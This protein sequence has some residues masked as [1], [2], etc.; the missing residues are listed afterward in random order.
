MELL[1]KILI[2]IHALTGGIGLISGIASIFVKKGSRLHTR[3]GKIFSWSMITSSV[4][5]LVVARLPGHENG[6]LF[7]IGL[8]TIYLVLAGNRAL[9]FRGGIK[10]QA[11]NIDKTISG[12]MLVLSVIMLLL[13]TYM[14]ITHAGGNAV[15]FVF[16]GGFGLFMTIKDFRTFRVYKIQRNAWLSSHIGRMVA[17]L[18]ASVTAFLIAGLH[19]H[20]LITW[21]LPSIIGTFYITYWNTRIKGRPSP[22]LA[23]S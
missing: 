6:F 19:F 23:N 13:G 15:L 7:L 10:P 20:T 14:L 4:V 16:F 12:T 1:F 17:A 22:S 9:T 11:D 21:I 8:F 3:S 5:S 18:T 2:Y